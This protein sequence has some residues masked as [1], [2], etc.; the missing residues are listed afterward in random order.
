MCLTLLKRKLRS[1]E[2]SSE[3]L[4]SV[5]TEAN[6]MAVLVVIVR[7]REVQLVHSEIRVNTD[8]TNK[9][10]THDSPSSVIHVESYDDDHN[11]RRGSSQITVVDPYHPSL[12]RSAPS[13]RSSGA[14]LF[15]RRTSGEVYHDD[16]F[17]PSS[18]K[19]SVDAVLPRRASVRHSPSSPDHH[20][21]IPEEQAILD[22]DQ[23][24]KK[25][26]SFEEEEEEEEG[27]EEGEEE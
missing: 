19:T 20:K 10:I 18:R 23:Q 15:P 13:R 6:D 14:D 5:T 12:Q 7:R 21:D 3:N 1:S 9:A 24:E 16:Q 26:V 11:L 4:F 27:E 2:S 8:Y 25:S 17:L 22:D